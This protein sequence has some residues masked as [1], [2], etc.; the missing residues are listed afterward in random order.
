LAIR[1]AE[2]APNSGRGTWLWKNLVHFG[3]GKRG[4]A[5]IYDSDLDSIV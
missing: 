3:Y 5:Q 2:G 4:M 1:I